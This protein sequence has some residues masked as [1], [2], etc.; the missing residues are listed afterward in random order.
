[1][2]RRVLLLLCSLAALFT[3]CSSVRETACAADEQR[4]VSELLYFGTA[5]PTGIVSIE[6]WSAFLGV[7]GWASHLERVI[8]A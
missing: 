7:S 1:M 8:G 5:K 3:G 6:E 4:S 2:P